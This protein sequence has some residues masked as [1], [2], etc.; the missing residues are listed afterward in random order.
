VEGSLKILVIEDSEADFRLISRNLRQHGL[1]A[2]CVRV[3]TLDDLSGALARDQIDLALVDYHVPG[4]EIH[5]SLARIREEAPGLPIILLS[6]SIGEEAA[7]ELL[8]Q[9]VWD[10]VLKDR[11]ARLVPSIQRSLRE[12]A[13]QRGR[14]EAEEQMRLAAVAFENT[15]EGIMVADAE[16]RII[17]VNRAFTQITGHDPA[18]TLG[19]DLSVLGAEGE[20][21]DFYTKM[22]AW[23]AEH[24]N[25][26][27][28]LWNRRQDGHTY[29][30][31]F[32]I[33][34]VRNATSAVTHYVGVLTDISERK[35]A[36]ARIEHMAQHD[37]LTDLPNRMLLADR[38]HQAIAH[39]QRSYRRIAVLFVDLD[40]FKHV[41]DLLGHANG[42]R[43][44]IE[45]A[46]RLVASVRAS[47]TVARLSGDEFV[48]LLHDAG[49]GVEGTVRVVA[50]VTKSIA[51]PIQ[52]E[53][54]KIRLSASI[55]VSL[56]PKDGSTASVLLSN[57]DHAMYHA[58]SAGRSTYRFFSPEMDAKARERVSIE[59]DLREA[60]PRRQLRLFYQ[61]LVDSH[62]AEVVGYEGLLRWEHP[63]RGLLCPGEFL[64]VAE[65]TGLIVPIG[66]WVMKQACA[67][68]SRWHAQGFR[69]SVAVN[70]SA[71]Q[72]GQEN[73][74]EAVK[75]SLQRVELPGTFLELELTE[76][77]LVEPTEATMR[78]LH[79]LRA[80][81][82][83]IA[84]DDFG[85][86]YSSLSYLKRYPITTL[87]IA[88]PFV[89][90]VA[91]ESGDRAIV[92]AIVSLARAMSLRTVAEGVEQA[93]QVQALREIGAD[94]LQGYYFGQ[95]A[96]I[97]ELQ[98]IAEP[99]QAI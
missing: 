22:W 73:L 71:R 16:H 61:P 90:E 94:L 84:V 69:G 14:R 13:E 89:E 15:L 85:T 37:P 62:T 80:L 12:V 68:C 70:L 29:P 83:R 3:A 67:Q 56:F 23:I 98:L 39:A 59:A 45:V 28:E 6:G 33:A 72:F 36:Q 30:A 26:H 27:G 65:E 7:V 32:N 51:E 50:G 9:G 95:P 2:E 57:A 43:V 1:L 41:N 17:S 21:D 4:L 81:G 34:A 75:E 63:E 24:G 20:D 42:D 10:F 66:E 60:L 18:Q 47:D 35:A 53:G 25:W 87:K 40:H 92:Q 97:S 64:G 55:G 76:S 88:Q 11:L 38:M 52:V 58:K 46:R 54:H 99:H 91:V 93:S 8:K 96:P 82:V 86:G 78:L 44:L 79:D 49:G 5:D 74:L 77:L 19:S 48:V 31:W